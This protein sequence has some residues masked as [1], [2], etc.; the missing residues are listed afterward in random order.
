MRDKLFPRQLTHNYN[1]SPVAKWVFIFLAIITIGR[2][3]VH[4]FAPDG[5]AH[6]IAT[7]P[8]DTFTARQ[9]NKLK[10]NSGWVTERAR[11]PSWWAVRAAIFG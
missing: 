9:G 2:S 6:S 4:V 3:L 5:G 10:C 7:I 1:G 8:L 11:S